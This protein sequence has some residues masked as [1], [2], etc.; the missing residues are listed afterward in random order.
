MSYKCVTFYS[1]LEFLLKSLYIPKLH[2]IVG[3]F[4][5]NFKSCV[6]RVLHNENVNR[7]SKSLISQ[8]S[9][10]SFKSSSRKE[11]IER[12]FDL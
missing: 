6:Q 5:R 8:S 4:N 11:K 3:Q 9:R 12:G 10:E 2:E 7:Y 1:N